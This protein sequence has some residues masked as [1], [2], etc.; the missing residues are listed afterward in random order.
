MTVGTSI[1]R[2]YLDKYL[3]FYYK[4]NLGTIMSVDKY[5]RFYYNNHLGELSNKLLF[6]SKRHECMNARMRIPL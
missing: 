6:S 1:I 3:V 2:I 4:N 5:F